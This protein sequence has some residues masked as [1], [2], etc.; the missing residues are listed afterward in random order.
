MTMRRSRIGGAAA[1]VLA[2]NVAASAAA[3]ADGTEDPR[4]DRF[5]DSYTNETFHDC[6]AFGV[7]WDL[8]FVSELVSW[9]DQQL[10]RFEHHYAYWRSTDHAALGSAEVH[11][12]GLYELGDDGVP[13]AYTLLGPATYTL[14]DGR[15]LQESGAI[16]HG[17]DDAVV[18]QTGEH[19]D[20][21][22]ALC[23]VGAALP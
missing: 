6:G 15:V 22:A 4:Y 3:G 21:R 5:E 1:L 14:A 17:A 12:T 2:M 13:L 11:Q 23:D 18:W 10:G 20:I 16:T 7:G 8:D 9:G 19:P